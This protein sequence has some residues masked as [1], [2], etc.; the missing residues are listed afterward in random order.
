MEINKIREEIDSIDKELVDLFIRRMNCSAAV[1]EYKR[2]NGMPVLDAS[3]ERALL[4]RISELSGEEFEE[5]S[6][7]LYSTILDL[8]RSY[9]HKQL[10]ENCAVYKEMI[11]AIENTS[12]L[13]RIET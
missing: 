6:R 9:Q 11:D 4:S 13:F 10:N 8:S 5:Y 12:K 1:A 7:T 2:Q 3:R